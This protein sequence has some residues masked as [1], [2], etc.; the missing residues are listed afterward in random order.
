VV[1]ISALVM[2]RAAT[3]PSN[4]IFFSCNGSD[5]HSLPIG[6]PALVVRGV[7]STL[8]SDSRFVWSLVWSYGVRY[9]CGDSR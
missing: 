9:G 8:W 2:K 1:D 5:I 4:S 6:T 3:S 7:D